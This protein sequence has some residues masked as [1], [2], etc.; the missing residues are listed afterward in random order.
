MVKLPSARSVDWRQHRMQVEIAT[1]L[2]EMPLQ[3]AI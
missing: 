1:G 3:H 2:D